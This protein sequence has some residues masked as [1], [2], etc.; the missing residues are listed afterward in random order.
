[1]SAIVFGESLQFVNGTFIDQSLHTRATHY[2]TELRPL[3][4][5]GFNIEGPKLSP[6][7]LLNPDTRK[8][9]TIYGVTGKGAKPDVPIVSS[10]IFG[11]DDGWRKKY[12][13]WTQTWLVET[14]LQREAQRK[15]IVKR[16][17]T[18]LQK[19]VDP[20]PSPDAELQAVLAPP[21]TSRIRRR[22][23]T[24]QPA[25]EEEKVEIEGGE[26]EDEG[27]KGGGEEEDGKAGGGE[28]KEDEAA[29]DPDAD[30]G[31]PDEVDE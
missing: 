2:R 18:P 26:E 8:R 16:T 25:E 30:D 5:D 14:V 19:L 28:E 27:E 24:P 11:A 1:M 21:R 12:D 22:L 7:K 13:D 23:P 29:G 20:D 31:E 10:S 15:G 4:L 17:K 6:L 9:K 3:L